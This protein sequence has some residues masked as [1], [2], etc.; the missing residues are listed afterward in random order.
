MCFELRGRN[1]LGL[2]VDG[3]GQSEQV[4]AVCGLVRPTGGR[5]LIDGEDVG[6]AARSILKRGVTHIPEDRHKWA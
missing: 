1:P 2:R 5:I 4:K 6:Q 3:I